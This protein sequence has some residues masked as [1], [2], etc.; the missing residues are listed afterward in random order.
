MDRA[1]APDGHRD[2]TRYGNEKPTENSISA[3]RRTFGNGPSRRSCRRQ[4]TPARIGRRGE[5]GAPVG[6]DV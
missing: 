1:A 6:G 5:G 3:V 4:A 2:R